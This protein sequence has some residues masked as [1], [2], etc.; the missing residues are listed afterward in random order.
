MTMQYFA[1]LSNNTDVAY[2]TAAR[3]WKCKTFTCSAP[4]GGVGTHNE[5]FG[6]GAGA[7]LAAGSRNVCVGY[8][9]G[10]LWQVWH[11]SVAIGY[12]AAQAQAD[13]PTVAIGSEAGRYTTGGGSVLIGCQ[14]GRGT[15][16]ISTFQQSVVIGYNAGN[17]LTTGNSNNV[18]GCFAGGWNYSS[19]D[20]NN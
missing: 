15:N 2:D 17:K 10:S 1:L 14:A 16:G 9:A 3:A 4:A 6:I 7:I 13:S 12:C 20:N 8:N 18:I 11:D 19:I 5:C